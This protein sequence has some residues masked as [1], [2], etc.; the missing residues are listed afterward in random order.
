MRLPL[1]GMLEATGGGQVGGTLVG[2]A[3]SSFHTD[4]RKVQEGGVFFALRGAETDGHRFID[5]AIEHGASAIVVESEQKPIHG[6]AQV[7]VDDT[8]RALYDL[9]SFTLDRVQPLVV[10]S[11]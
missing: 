7:V 9:A 5:D 8:W 2:N 10:G 6:V 11:T 4:S 3:F 1:L